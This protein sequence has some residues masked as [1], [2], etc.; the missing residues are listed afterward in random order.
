LIVNVFITS[1]IFPGWPNIY[2]VSL[3]ALVQVGS[4]YNPTAIKPPGIA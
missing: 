1:G 3:S 4:T 2:P